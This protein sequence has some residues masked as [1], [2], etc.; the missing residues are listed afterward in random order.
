MTAIGGSIESISIKGREFAVASDADSNR[1]LGGFE[2]ELR[3]N[4]D[5]TGR[6]IKTRVPWR[7]DN[8]TIVIDDTRGDHEYLQGLADRKDLFPVGITF[9]SGVTYG[10]TG[11]VSG[12]MQ[13]SSQATTAAL[14]L[15]GSGKLTRQ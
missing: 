14:S 5:G 11:Q 15:E 4:G 1:K 13:V 9:A 3:A 7:L 6:L 10:G 12:E 2:N 8:L